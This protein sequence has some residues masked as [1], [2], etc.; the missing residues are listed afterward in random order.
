MWVWS[1]MSVVT[2]GGAVYEI[3]SRVPYLTAH[4]ALGH[5]W[6]VMRTSSST[7]P[8][9]LPV[10]Q[11]AVARSPTRP[12]DR[13]TVSPMSLEP[14]RTARH[15]TRDGRR[16]NAKGGWARLVYAGRS[17]GVGR[18]ACVMRECRS[19]TRDV[20][21]VAR[22]LASHARPADVR[23]SRPREPLCSCGCKVRRGCRRVHP[24]V[25]DQAC[26]CRS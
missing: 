23:W 17:G 12:R 25:S 21:A 11:P 14:T 1:A 18:G 10:W 4:Q 20:V 6:P 5:P 9:R 13:Q 7:T 19:G 16:S 3:Q 2:S 8:R 24:Y 26:G 22:A 15:K